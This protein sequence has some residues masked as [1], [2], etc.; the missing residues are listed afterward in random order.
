MASGANA[1]AILWQTMRGGN[2]VYGKVK[3]CQSNHNCLQALKAEME[4]LNLSSQSA[5][6]FFARARFAWPWRAT[7]L[8]TARC[9]KA[10]D[11]LLRQSVLLSSAR[12]HRVG[13]SE[14]HAATLQ[15]EA[16]RG[17]SAQRSPSLRASRWPDLYRGRSG[18]LRSTGRQTALRT[19]IPPRQA[20]DRPRSDERHCWRI[21]S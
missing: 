3:R 11:N 12:A 14:N 20:L 5:D 13:A 21:C 17:R 15:R 4:A 16:G 1:R 8:I 19:S 9:H 7:T 10:G 18:L 2:R 6:P